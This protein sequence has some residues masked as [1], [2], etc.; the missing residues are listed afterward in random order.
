[1]RQANTVSQ[2]TMPVLDLRRMPA[3]P[4][5]GDAFLGQQLPA[6]H[7]PQWEFW[8]ASGRARAGRFA[9]KARHLVVIMLE[10]GL[11]L[12]D[13]T[14]ETRLAAGDSALIAPDTGFDWQCDAP[15]LWIVNGYA[16]QTAGTPPAPGISR[17]D[18]NAAQRP[19]PS[20]AQHLLV[21]PAPDCTKLELAGA[22][23]GCWGAG[24]WTA[25]AYERIPIRYGYYEM[26][27]LHAGAVT[28][29]DE[30]GATM[31]FREGDLFLMPEGVVAGWR[32]TAD[33]RKLWSIFTPATT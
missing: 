19:S 10:G 12:Q 20:P 2:T 7:H 8:R 1:M 14:A 33:V 21:G 16:D 28:V 4:D 3:G 30:T 13:G 18:R 6:S 5:A 27:H 26:M 29:F 11:T 17:I 15:A 24:L 31:T 32:S 22:G 9:S 23:D 25:T